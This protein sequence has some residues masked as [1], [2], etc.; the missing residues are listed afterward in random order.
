MSV[1]VLN[2]RFVYED[3]DLEKKEKKYRV[4]SY[5]ISNKKKSRYFSNLWKKNIDHP[6]IEGRK[7]NYD[8][9]HYEIMLYS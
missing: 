3:E 8:R 1:N 4:I 9:R 5:V 2:I 7:N 6:Q